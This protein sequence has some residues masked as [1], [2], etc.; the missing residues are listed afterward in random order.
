MSDLHFLSACEQSAIDPQPGALA[1]NLI[2][3][4]LERIQRYDGA[5]RAYITV[6]GEQRPIQY[7]DFTVL[8]NLGIEPSA[9]AVR[10]ES[11]I[12]S[13]RELFDGA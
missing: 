6:C 13:G 3:V 7:T 5:L 1:G 8:A 11:P 10:T 2:R 4:C 9:I 12:K